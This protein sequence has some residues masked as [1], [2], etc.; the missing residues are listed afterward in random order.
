MFLSTCSRDYRLRPCVRSKSDLKSSQRQSMIDVAET[1]SRVRDVNVSDDQK[2]DL[3]NRE[4]VRLLAE[5]ERHLEAYVHALIPAWQDAED[6]LQ[7]TKL[8]LWE[9]FDSFRPEGDFAAWAIAIAG[10]MVRTHRTLSQRQRVCFSDDLL[11]KISQH[12]PAPSSRQDDRILA[13]VECVG[14]LTSTSRKLLRL[15]CTGQRKIKDIAHEL[16]QTPS[17]TY[18]ALYRIRWSLFDCVQ[19][20]LKKGNRP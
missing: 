5:H 14:A 18:S 16:G 17:A 11:E 10:Y 2:P 4:F 9:Q 20:R 3:R 12:I 13:L 19:E 8:R 15:F 6:V 1:P 7:N